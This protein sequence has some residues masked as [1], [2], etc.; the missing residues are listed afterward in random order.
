MKLRV[1][2]ATISATV[3]LAGGCSTP[4]TTPSAVSS[5]AITGNTFFDALGLTSQLTA[6]AT[7]TDGTNSQVSA[8]AIW[9]SSNDL[10][11]AVS[12]GGLVTVKGFGAADITATYRGVAGVITVLVMP[13]PPSP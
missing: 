8:Q 3:V 12:V 4:T 10:V 11:A 5:I 6:T 7:L 1:L 9:Q 13:P 2:V